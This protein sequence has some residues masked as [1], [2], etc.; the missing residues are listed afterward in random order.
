M[1][2][3]SNPPTSFLTVIVIHQLYVRK[4]I[5]EVTGLERAEDAPLQPTAPQFDI[6]GMQNHDDGYP[7]PV[8]E[9][10]TT[11]RVDF[12]GGPKSDWNQQ[13]YGILAEE[14]ERRGRGNAELQPEKSFNYWKELVIARLKEYFVPWDLAQVQQKEDGTWESVKESMERLA[15]KINIR[16]EGC[17]RNMRIAYVSAFSYFIVLDCDQ[18]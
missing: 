14:L 9:K 1:S 18:T 13:L 6:V 4:F 15:R 12:I 17:R 5:T 7:G 10:G 11:L 8:Y 3:H 16:N 2:S